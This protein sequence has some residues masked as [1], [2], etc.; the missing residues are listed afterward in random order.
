MKGD[1]SQFTR[2]DDVAETWRIVQPLLDTPP[3]IE[4]YQPGSW[5]PPGADKLLTGHPPGAN[6]GFANRW[7]GFEPTAVAGADTV[8]TQRDVIATTNR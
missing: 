3:P 6:P 1:S 5:G 4:S 8:A 7:P 2:Q